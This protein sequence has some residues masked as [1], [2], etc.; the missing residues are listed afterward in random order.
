MR[1]PHLNDLGAGLAGEV[2]GPG[3]VAVVGHAGPI[4]HQHPNT[5]QQI[6]AMIGG[7]RVVGNRVAFDAG[8][9]FQAGGL[10]PPVEAPK[11]AWPASSQACRAACIMVILPVP[12]GPTIVSTVA[13]DSTVRATAAYL[14]GPR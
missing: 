4:D 6:G 5:L 2:V 3:T 12:A 1:V 9:T 8:V 14:S 7:G 11:T 10:L 13:G